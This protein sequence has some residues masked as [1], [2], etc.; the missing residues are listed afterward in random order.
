[1]PQSDGDDSHADEE[2]VDGGDQGAVGDGQHHWDLGALG[3]LGLP[4]DV[5]AAW[6]EAEAE[7]ST[8]RSLPFF[9]HNTYQVHD[10]PD[11][12][13]PILGRIKPVREGTKFEC[14]SVYCRRHGCSKMVRVLHMPSQAAI[15]EWF[16]HDMDAGA[17][18]KS[19]HLRAWPAKGS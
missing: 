15:L 10:G 1:M 8:A 18:H 12:S 17:Q 16:K 6:A 5:E 14:I 19:A 4:Q 9:D 13:A 2:E 3:D 11:S 7:A